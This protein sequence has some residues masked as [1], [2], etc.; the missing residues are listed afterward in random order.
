MPLQRY[1]VGVTYLSIGFVPVDIFGKIIEVSLLVLDR[2]LI[3]LFIMSVLELIVKL[4][5]SD[6]FALGRVGAL[7]RGFLG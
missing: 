2:F 1:A 4:L 7:V 3:Q 6:V 5:V